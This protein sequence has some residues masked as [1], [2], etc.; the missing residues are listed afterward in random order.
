MRSQRPGAMV[1]GFASLGLPGLA[2]FW[3]EFFV[4]RGAYAI[5]P[6][7]AIIGVLA[8]TVAVLIYR[9]E[10]GDPRGSIAAGDRSIA[11]LPFVNMSNEPSNEYFSD[12]ISEEVLNVLANIPG[13]HVASRTSAFAFRVRSTLRRADWLVRLQPMSTSAHRSSSRPERTRMVAPQPA[14]RPPS[15]RSPDDEGAGDQE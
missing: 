14:R 7:F 12:G 13:L 6:T 11:V 8:V 3:S 1:T 5:I 2:G 4:F 9:G 10:W 15:T